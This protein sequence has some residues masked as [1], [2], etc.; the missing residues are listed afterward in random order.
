MKVSLLRALF[1]L[2]SILR[3]NHFGLLWLYILPY[4]CAKHSHG[5]YAPL[6]FL[7]NRCNGFTRGKLL[8]RASMGIALL[9]AMR[10]QRQ[11]I[12]LLCLIVLPDRSLVRPQTQFRTSCQPIKLSWEPVLL[13]QWT[14][15]N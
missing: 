9:K 5:S 7:L 11:Y 10:Q 4:C 15:E 13:Q 3:L 14:R 8:L 1:V 12:S 2:F 6:C